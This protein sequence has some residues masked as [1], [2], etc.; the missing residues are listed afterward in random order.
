M[1]P[2]GFLKAKKLLQFLRQRKNQISRM[3]NP[4]TFLRLLRDYDLLPEGGYKEEERPVTKRKKTVC[5]DEEEQPGPSSQLNPGQRKKP[6]NI[7]ISSPLKKGERSQLPV[8]CGDKKGT[9]Y[10]DRMAKGQGDKKN[11]ENDD[12]CYICKCGEEAAELVLCDHCPRSFHQKCHL[13][14]VDDADL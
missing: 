10:R 13:P 12:E 1:D 2:L 8:T 9:L 3:E 6:K 7:T 5:S 4:Q 14:H 11:R